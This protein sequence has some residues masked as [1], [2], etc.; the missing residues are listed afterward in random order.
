MEKRVS[1][2]LPLSPSAGMNVGQ[3]TFHENI[4]NQQFNL[5]TI[6]GYSGSENPKVSFFLKEVS[7]ADTFDSVIVSSVSKRK[8]FT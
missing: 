3:R 1:F 7:L 5:Y 2:I 8:I 6:N 4:V